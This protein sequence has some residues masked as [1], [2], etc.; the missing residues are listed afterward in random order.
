VRRALRQHT[1]GTVASPPDKTMR[2]R[3]LNATGEGITIV[4]LVPRHCRLPYCHQVRTPHRSGSGVWRSGS[5]CESQSLAG[6]SPVCERRPK[7]LRSSAED[8]GAEYAHISDPKRFTK[9]LIILNLVAWV[10]KM[11]RAIYQIF[12]RRI[13]Y[14]CTNHFVF[15][16]LIADSRASICCNSTSVRAMRC[17]AY[18]C[19]YETKTSS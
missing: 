13:P 17:K 3:H 1:I 6:Q 11:H 4:C 16:R 12:A 8:S 18:S 14:R 10:P 15:S 5:R 7:L 9:L 2:V 19:N